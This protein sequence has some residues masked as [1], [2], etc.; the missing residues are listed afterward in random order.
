MHSHPQHLRLVEGGDQRGSAGRQSDPIEL[1]EVDHALQLELCNVLE[2]LADSLPNE[3]DLPLARVAMTIL[4]SGFPTHHELEEK[5]FF[6][7]LKSRT[8]GNLE[9]KHILDQFEQEHETDESFAFEIADELER[10]V[11]DGEVRNPEMLGYMLR[12]FFVS[13]RRHIEWEN[14]IVIPMARQCLTACDLATLDIAI[15]NNAQMNQGRRSLESI[16]EDFAVKACSGECEDCKNKE[17][18]G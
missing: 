4:R 8:Q 16:P 15:S 5:H 9:F 13:Q 1:L 6:P 17:D 3:V 18:I 11:E 2:H 7:I 14:A 12:G 10:I